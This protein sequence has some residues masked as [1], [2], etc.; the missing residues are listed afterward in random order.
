MSELQHIHSKESIIK[1]IDSFSYTTALL[2]AMSFCFYMV[3]GLYTIALFIGII[4][5]CFGLI[6]LLN[7]KKHHKAA[8]FSIIS[9]SII[10]ILIFSAYLGFNSGFV[11]YIFASPHLIYLLFNFRKK[12]PLY[13][14]MFLYIVAF[15]LTFILDYFKI[16]N[17]ITIPPH[18]K[19]IIFGLNFIFSLIFCFVLISIFAKNND[20]YIHLLEET[21]L[22]LNEKVQQKNKIHEQLTQ[23]LNDKDKLLAEV[24][25]RV[26]N[27]LAFISG[28]LELQNFYVS[29]A[30][31]SNILSDSSTRIKAI[32]L[33]HEK[34]YEHKSLEQIEFKSF[35]DI[36]IK[37]LTLR[38]KSKF[39]QNVNYILN[40]D[41]I[42]LQMNK[43][44][45]LSLL[46]NE[47]ITNSLK[48]AFKNIE[49]PEIQIKVKLDNSTINF[50]YTD[51]GNGFNLKN[52]MKENSLGLNLIDAFTKQLKSQ[53]DFYSES[54]KGISLKLNFT[55]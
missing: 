22:L 32:A 37:H 24:H 20:E 11:F 40:I 31:L 51:N 50:L 30:T 46:I 8:K 36:L 29:D 15:I 10:G 21:N 28:L 2:T 35:I 45:P 7:K 26:K 52:E 39:N 25:H 18:I 44:L 27:N 4:S 19:D 38:Y 5:L 1:T 6:I 48:H 16:F 49:K 41:N 33:L 53:K 47:L 54:N 17:G 23:N 55:I 9:V 34:F 3:L 12:Q 14:S 43:A 13:L 42:H